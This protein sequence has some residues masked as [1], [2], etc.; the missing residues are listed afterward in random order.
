MRAQPRFERLDRKHLCSLLECAFTG[1]SVQATMEKS[2]I[3]M[4]VADDELCL[5]MEFDR[6][7]I[8]QQDMDATFSEH[9][10]VVVLVDGCFR[11]GEIAEW[12][13]IDDVSSSVSRKYEVRLSSDS[14]A[15][16]KQVPHFNVYKLPRTA[17]VP[18]SPSSLA[19]S[20]NTPETTEVSAGDAWERLK[21]A[22]HEMGKLSPFDYKTAWNKVAAEVPP[23]LCG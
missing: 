14:N 23:R 4:E 7:S 17:T 5:G 11:L 22:L 8:A 16:P 15:R 18:V 21:E 19:L 10:Q 1:A 6:G 9:E 13:A 20:E 2:D 12:T 3:A